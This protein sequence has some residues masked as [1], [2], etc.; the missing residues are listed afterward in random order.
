MDFAA[1]DCHN[2]KWRIVHDGM[3]RLEFVQ[4]GNVAFVNEKNTVGFI[5]HY[6]FHLA[7]RI[8]V[9]FLGA[10]HCQL[11]IIG[12]VHS[13]RL[14][15]FGNGIEF[16]FDMDDFSGV[17]WKRRFAFCANCANDFF[18]KKF[19]ALGFYQDPP[20]ICNHKYFAPPMIRTSHSISKFVAV[21]LESKCFAAATV[22]STALSVV[23]RFGPK[24][25][26]G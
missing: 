23:F 5:N 14:Q 17:H 12:N 10:L 7:A 26:K 9:Q 18:E 11:G 16:N 1:L 20:P 8:I 6:P 3:E 25:I 22:K 21:A 13:R 15:C 2:L 19:N 24:S 4:N